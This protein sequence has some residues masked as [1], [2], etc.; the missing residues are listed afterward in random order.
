MTGAQCVMGDGGH[1]AGGGLVQAGGHCP[2]VGEISGHGDAI[3]SGGA[4]HCLPVM[5]IGT[6]RTR[7]RAATKRRPD[8]GTGGPA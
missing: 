1:V 3:R 8:G 7:D 2:W 4:R 6:D 5:R